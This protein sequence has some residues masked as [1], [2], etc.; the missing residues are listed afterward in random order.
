MSTNGQLTIVV[1]N[2][3]PGVEGVNR[4]VES[5]VGRHPGMEDAIR[6]YGSIMEIQQDVLSSLECT[7]DLPKSRIDSML[8]GGTSLLEH[9]EVPLDPGVFRKTVGRIADVVAAKSPGGFEKSTDLASWEGLSDANA[10]GTRDLVVSGGPLEFDE[11]WSD[12]DAGVA[13]S[14]MWEALYPFYRVCGSRLEGRIDQ[15]IWHR[16]SCPVCG[17]RP[18]IGKL[19]DDDGLWL[20]ECSLCHTLWNLKRV[21]CAFCEK[22]KEGTREYFYIDDDRSRRVMYCSACSR[23]VKTIDIREGGNDI[24]LALED[25]V[26]I[27]L[28]QAAAE[29][30]LKPA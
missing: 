24:L 13:G 28:D 5:C 15:T 8:R 2:D 17:S 29:E 19:R 20:V 22:G 9:S 30:G 18:L 7:I 12:H 23:Y 25:I 4:A 11:S 6:L 10:A 1:R 27:R 14:V 16:G 21:G 3:P 26:T